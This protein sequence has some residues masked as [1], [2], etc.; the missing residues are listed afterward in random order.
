MSWA[1]KKDLYWGIKILS[2][3]SIVGIVA[4]IL[5]NIFPAYA[6]PIVYASNSVIIY[7]MIL[8]VRKTEWK[9]PFRMENEFTLLVQIIHIRMSARFCLE[10]ATKFLLEQIRSLLDVKSGI[11]H[12]EPLPS[13]IQRD[14]G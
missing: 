8:V 7:L 9:L 11:H 14:F 1:T 2:L 4:I 13:C 5:S 3:G 10:R 6:V 12:C